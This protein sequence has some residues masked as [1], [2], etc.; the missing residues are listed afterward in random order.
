MV[1]N[2]PRDDLIGFA[3]DR[4]GKK[5]AREEKLVGRTQKEK[6]EKKK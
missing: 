5:I 6:T 3:S 1:P 4:K 2:R